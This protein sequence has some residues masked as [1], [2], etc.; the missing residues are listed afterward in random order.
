MNIQGYPYPFNMTSDQIIQLLKLTASLLELHDE[1]VFKIKSYNTAVFNLDKAVEDFSALP[2]AALEKMDGIGK[3]LAQ[4]IDAI[5]R[6]GSFEELDQLLA[7]TPAGV[8]EM[9]NI[10]GIGPKKVRSIWK[11]LGIESLDDLLSACEAGKIAALKGFGDKTQETIMQGIQFKAA[12]KGKLLFAQA[13]LVAN[14][15]MIYLQNAGIQQLSMVGELRRKLEII[16]TLQILV[17]TMPGIVVHELLNQLPYLSVD[18]LQGGPFVWKGVEQTSLCKVE[19]RLC[20]EADFVKELMIQTGSLAHLQQEVEAGKSILSFIKQNKADSE[21]AMFAQMGMQN[22]APELREGTFEV[23]LAKLHQLPTLVNLAD[24]KGILH[25][26]STYSDGKHTLAQMAT[27]CKSLGY[28]YLGICDHSKSAQYAGGLYEE[29]VLLQHQEIDLL[30]TQLAPFKI[31]KGIESDILNDGSLDYAPEVLGSF[32]FI[33]ASIHSNL[34]MDIQKATNRLLRAIENPYTTML[35][36]PTGRLLLRREAYP[37]DHKVIIDACAA[38]HVIIEINA[39][40][41]RLDLDWRWVHYALEK[42]VMLSINPDAHEMNGYHD[43]YYGVCVG[44]KGG[45]SADMTFNA[46]SCSEVAAKFLQK[47]TNN[48]AT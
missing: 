4:K 2:L 7:K 5:I 38:N 43:M 39:N 11:T 10:K 28:E 27:Y 48:F 3:S 19:V 15:L 31:F 40:P 42:G 25:N 45:L 22:I 37:I 35:G 34:K 6:V 12:Q 17:V 47:K 46:L 8:L 23:P 29:K 41:R 33:V 1:N 30:N 20:K 16:E 44:R 13:E 32:D 36:H 18:A 26:H 21:E 14:N 9:M 24:L